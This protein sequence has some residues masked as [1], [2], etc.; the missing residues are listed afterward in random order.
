MSMDSPGLTQE[1][2]LFQFLFVCSKMDA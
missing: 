1:A 2:A